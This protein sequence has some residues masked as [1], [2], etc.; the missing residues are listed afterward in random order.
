MKQ[1]NLLKNIVHFHNKSRPKIMKGKGNRRDTYESGDPFYEGW[2]FTVDVF[3]SGIFAIKGT[4]GERI[5]TLTPRQMLERLPIALVQTS[6]NLL[7][8]KS[9]IIY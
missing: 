2:Q 3:E 7:D 6:E 8:Q 4:K 5:T 9:Q 1:S